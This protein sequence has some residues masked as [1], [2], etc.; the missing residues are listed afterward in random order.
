MYAMTAF[1]EPWYTSGPQKWK[2]TAPTLN[3][4]AAIIINT[5]MFNIGECDIPMSIA[6]RISFKSKDPVE[7]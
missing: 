5:P 3:M 6:M 7:P 4:N 2:G 1:E